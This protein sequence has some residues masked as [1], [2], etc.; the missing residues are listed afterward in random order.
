MNRKKHPQKKQNSFLKQSLTIVCIVTCILLVLEL[1]SHLL[2][3]D[4]HKVQQGRFRK[5]YQIDPLITSGVFLLDEHTFW[6]VAPDEESGVNSAGFRDRNAITTEKPDGAY[7]I[8]CIGDSVTFGVPV[9]LNPP[10]KTFSKQLEALM[11]KRFGSGKVEVLNAGNPGYTSYQGL[12][13]LKH[14][15][16]KYKPD[17]LIVQ[18]AINDSSPAVGQTDKEQPTR[19]E[20]GLSLYNALSKSALCCAIVNLFRRN[21]QSAAPSNGEVQRVPPTDFK[22]NMLMI[23]A[24]G[25]LHGFECLFIKPVRLEKGKLMTPTYHQPPR[26][27]KAVDTL[28]SFKN[29]PNDPTQLFHD[30][31]HLTPE[32]H[33]LLA[34]TIFN[35]INEYEMLNTEAL[36]R[37]ASSGITGSFK[38]EFKESQ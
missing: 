15:L 4:F 5:G 26:N 3:Q 12:K 9:H 34:E 25:K 22:K 2:L 18:F 16:L 11:D 8:I 14:R 31:C 33:K 24:Q 36:G 35:A 1:A 7:R 32:G 10:E 17:L 21:P 6:K 20:T 28:A 27:A 29:Y 37:P 19:T 23:M 13:Q 30:A 38:L